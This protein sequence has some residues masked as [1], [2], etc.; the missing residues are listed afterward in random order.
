[1]QS[2][3]TLLPLT[4]LF[5]A[6]D[7][8][9]KGQLFSQTRPSLLLTPCDFAV[10]EG[11]CFPHPSP[12][13]LLPLKPQRKEEERFHRKNVAYSSSLPSLLFPTSKPPLL[14]TETQTNSRRRRREGNAD[15]WPPAREFQVS[16]IEISVL[17]YPILHQIEHKFKRPK[18][19]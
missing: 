19:K 11:D 3:K 12:P 14:S 13:S 9:T 18:I 2:A 15:D 8:A 1:M 4:E 7:H 17:L 10:A 6:M 16:V 5:G